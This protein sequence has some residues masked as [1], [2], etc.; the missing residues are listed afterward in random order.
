MSNKAIF[1]LAVIGILVFDF[2]IVGMGMFFDNGELDASWEL[3]PEFFDWF[4]I[5][6]NHLVVS[7]SILVAILAVSIVSLVGVLLFKP[8]GR[9]FYLV[10]TLLMFPVSVI[11][12]PAIYYGWETALFDLAS[13][14]HGAIILSMFLQPIASEFSGVN[15]F[16]LPR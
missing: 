8:W 7:I 4:S 9:G 5:I 16:D 12:G 15:K 6:E 3:L 1:R 13:M 11:A 10:T 14:F 2:T